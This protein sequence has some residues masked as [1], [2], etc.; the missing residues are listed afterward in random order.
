MAKVLRALQ[1]KDP[2]GSNTVLD[3]ELGLE[4]ALRE[5]F[6][7]DSWADLLREVL[8]ES[9]G[10]GL[11][12]TVAEVVLSDES[13]VVHL[14]HVGALTQSIS[15]LG[16][17]R[18]FRSNDARDL[19][20]HGSSCVLV[21]FKQITVGVNAAN[22]AE[23]FVIVDD[24]EVLLIVSFETLSNS[25][26]VV[27]RSALASLKQTLDSGLL[28]AIEEEHILSFADICLE[29]CALV[30]FSGESID[31]VVLFLNSDNYG[32]TVRH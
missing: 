27:I 11:F 26:R 21:N 23:L 31:Q 19:G 16:L 24:R 7:E 9:H 29:V 32:D 1:A 3:E 30:Y 10:L 5:V 13:V 22:L 28:S 4:L 25:L 8:N 14:L 6:Q 20:E 12:I 15:E 2:R 18:C 17:A